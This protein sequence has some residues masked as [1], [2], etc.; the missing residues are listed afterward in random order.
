MVMTGKYGTLPP[1]EITFQKDI[2]FGAR[3]FLVQGGFGNRLYLDK[4]FC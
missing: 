4:I 2:I 1:Q 3:L